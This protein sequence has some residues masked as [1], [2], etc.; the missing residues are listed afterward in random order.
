MIDTVPNQIMVLRSGPGGA[1][2]TGA[3]TLASE[4]QAQGR[5]V[6][7]VL[8]QDAVLA[9]LEA[10][11]LDSAGLLRDLLAAGASCYYLADDLAMRGFR[12]SDLAAGCTAIGYPE[13]VD[14]LL[15]DGARVSGAF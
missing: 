11:E 5:R 12:P 15:I 13:L 14:L 10:S 7:L 2:S 8:V 1:E 6:T 9:G 4:L 3:L